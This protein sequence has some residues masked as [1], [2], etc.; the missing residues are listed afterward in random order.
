ME[1]LLRVP[2]AELE[3]GERVL[4]PETA[5]YVA[6]VHRLA[7]GDTFLAFD[8]DAALEA[9][10]SILSVERG[11]VLVGVEMPLRATA[12]PGA[13]LELIQGLGKGDKPDQVVK[14]ATVLGATRLIWASAERSVAQLAKNKLE[15]R[16]ARWR[17]LAVEAARQCGRGDLPAIVGPV[18]LS[19]A[20]AP[21]EGLVRQAVLAPPDASGAA[22]GLL[23]WLQAGR[24]ETSVALLIGPEGGLSRSELELAEGRGFQRVSLGRFVLRT[25]TAATVALGVAACWRG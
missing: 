11:R 10:V 2:L 20:L 14:A 3:R 4:E 9:R 23:S 6:R 1:R 18:P 25:E 8:P 22:L 24:P 17:T 5:R 12:L 16:H 21:A 13:P 15:A 19:E 7:A